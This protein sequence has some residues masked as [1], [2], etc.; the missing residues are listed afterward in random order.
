MSLK[1]RCIL[2]IRYYN[3]L[4][5]SCA[6]RLKSHNARSHVPYYENNLFC[7]LEDQYC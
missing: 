7:T 2:R 6:V 4:P 1:I 5:H 3:S